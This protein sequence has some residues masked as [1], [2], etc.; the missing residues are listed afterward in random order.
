[1]EVSETLKR[2]WSAVE[3]AG[4]PERIQEAAFREAVRLLAPP[5]AGAM[6]EAPPQALTPAGYAGG[7]GGREAAGGSGELVSE[8]QV[9]DRVAAHT[10]VARDRLEQVVH[11]DGEVLKVSI[12]GLRLGRNNA[13]R[14]RAV[15]QLLTISRGFGFEESETP[16]EVIRAECD[17]LRVYDQNNFSSY[18]RALNGFVVTGTGGNRRLRAK[19]AGIA[20]FPALLDT[21]LG[22]E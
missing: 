6:G 12:P 3:T 11:L 13:E 5:P 21:L 17:R 19:S 16:L 8:D 14:S 7:A 20:A 18:I 4:L 22:G 10:G 1:M 15:A 9:Y 2:A